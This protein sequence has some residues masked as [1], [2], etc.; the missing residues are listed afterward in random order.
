MKKCLFICLLVQ[1]IAC[2]SQNKADDIVGY[3]LT[4]DPNTNEYSQCYIYKTTKG[5]YCGL[6]CW[7]SNPTK[8]N[9]LNYVFLTN[10]R[11]DAEN[12]EWVDGIITYAGVKGT[13]KAYMKF[14]S[15][16]V[17]K[18]RAYYGISLL[19]KTVYWSK[20]AKKRIQQ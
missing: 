16:N 8:K 12:N 2:F 20:E 14:D 19:G 5:T 15:K 11:F 10:L 4:L 13:Y 17:L 7:V 6:V 9:F 18:V 1:S 3:Y